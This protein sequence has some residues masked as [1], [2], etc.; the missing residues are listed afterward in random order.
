LRLSRTRIRAVPLIEAQAPGDSVPMITSYAVKWREA[1][2]QTFLGRLEFG[3]AALVLEGRDGAADAVWRTIAFEEVQDFRLA[4]SAG[5][6]L[7]RQPT[8]VIVH[9]RG[10]VLVT[11]ALVQAGVLLE[12]VHRLSE[13]RL[14][15]VDPAPVVVPPAD[16][17]S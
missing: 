7:E 14:R 1:S 8:L 4:Q 16:D 11:S 6:R 17:P 10:D 12:L 13:L 5:D 9:A 2:G 3:P 15:V